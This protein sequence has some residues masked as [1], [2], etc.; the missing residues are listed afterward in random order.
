MKGTDPWRS[1]VVVIETKRTQNTKA[2]WGVG[3]GG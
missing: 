3:S 2:T 1:G